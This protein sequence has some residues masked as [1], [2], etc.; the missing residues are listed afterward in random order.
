MRSSLRDLDMMYILLAKISLQREINKKIITI[1]QESAMTDTE[2]PDV[3]PDPAPFAGDPYRTPPA[4]TADD[5]LALPYAGQARM[6][7]VVAGGL[8][9]ARVVVD[10]AARALIRVDPGAG[11]P[12][13]LRLDRDTIRLGWAASFGEWVRLLFAGQRSPM[14]IALHP[15]VEW[16]I[17]LRGGAADVQFELA[18]GRVAGL[19]ISGGCSEIDV[20][21]PEPAR[22]A[23]IR[24]AGGVSGAR[25]RRPAGVGVSVAIAGG[26]SDLALDDQ[27]FTAIGGGARLHTG[28]APAAARYELA[29]AGG[30]SRLSVARV[31]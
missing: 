24:I 30:A 26:V 10:S 14:T 31:V 9:G 20:A 2:C 7:L 18:G 19:D 15:A 23:A 3:P 17:A 1:T 8:A 6:A 27:H 4:P 28:G 21:L 22:T 12:P 29:V 5:P 25:I 13:R 16:S 11:S